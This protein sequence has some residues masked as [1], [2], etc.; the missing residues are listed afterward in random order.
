M[1]FQRK[2]FTT[3]III[4]LIS[5]SAMA[6]TTRSVDEVKG[7]SVGA[8]VPMF[9][10]LD[11][12]GKKYNLKESLQKGPVVVLFYRGQ[13][14]PVCNRYLSLLQDS[15]QQIY[16]KGATVIAISPEKPEMLEITREKTNASF[17]LLHD[18]AFLIGEAFDVVF[19]P[20]AK[21]V[22][23]YNDKLKANLEGASSDGSSRLPVPATF[24][25]DRNGI[26]VWRHFNKDYRI[27]ANVIDIINNIPAN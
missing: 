1:N 6:Q 18:T 9:T 4:L 20:E 15:V 17:S 24:I 21:Q 13:W 5:I 11:V 8:T 7:L 27:R 26:I 3:I 12:D 19:N 16:D 2:H 10:T 23:M 22:S 25:L 14:C